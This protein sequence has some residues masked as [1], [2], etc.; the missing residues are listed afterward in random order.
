MCAHACVLC[1]CTYMCMYVCVCVWVYPCMQ[2]APRAVVLDCQHNRVKLFCSL[3]AVIQGR[4]ESGHMKG[5]P[6]PI[7]RISV[8]RLWTAQYILFPLFIKWMKNRAGNPVS[9]RF[10]AH[11]A[12]L[13]TRTTLYHY[14]AYYNDKPL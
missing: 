12:T 4:L 6:A 13:L 1:V 14:I 11:N 2:A 8:C 7:G 9:M 10:P 3:F 5:L